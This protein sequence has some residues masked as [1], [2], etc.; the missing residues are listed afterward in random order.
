MEK[1]AQERSVSEGPDGPGRNTVSIHSSG[2]QDLF[3]WAISTQEGIPHCLKGQWQEYLKT[4]PHPISG[5]E[6]SQLPDL[7]LWDDLAT[8]DHVVGACQWSQEEV[9]HLL[10]TLRAETQQILSNLNAKGD[11]R[12]VKT[13]SMSNNSS[14]AE[15]QRQ[16][17]RRF[18]YQQAEGPR[19]ACSRLRELCHCWLEP[20]SRTKEQILELLILEQFLTVLPKRIQSQVRERGPETCAQAV[21]LAEGFLLRSRRIWKVNHR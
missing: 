6:A 1:E 9:S 18:C 7:T 12:R 19:E 15:I 4:V 2:A 20:E 10:P 13:T 14:T 3:Q 17:F 11:H 16:R 21:A 8:F 5:W